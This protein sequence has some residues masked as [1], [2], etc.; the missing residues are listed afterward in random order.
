MWKWTRSIF[1]SLCFMAIVIRLFVGEVCAVSG[2]SMVH[3]ILPGDWLWINKTTYGA[4]MPECYLDIPVI[5]IL[6]WMIPS[7]ICEK[8]TNW[9]YKRIKG[10][11]SPQLGDMLV[12]NST[13]TKDAILVKRIVAIPGDSF[14][15][16]K[17]VLYSNKHFLIQ[18][19]T[20]IPASTLNR[21]AEYPQRTDWTEQDYG[22]V[23]LPKRGDTITITNDNF[24][25][26]APVIRY[27][28]NTLSLE[29]GK[30]YIN[31]KLDPVYCFK[32]NYY[33]VM[34]DNRSN[35]RDSRSF[36]FVSERAIIGMID[37]VLFSVDSE[38]KN[39]MGIRLNRLFHP[40]L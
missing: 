23:Y 29:R 32:Y 40:L 7:S 6:T 33:F 26:L 16:K 28:D 36:G 37:F 18:P 19:A 35:S 5:N 2:D 21:L 14:L 13:E 25:Y 15:I 12:F 34:G 10:T 20:V 30:C 9:D 3:T 39:W 27:E 24:L 22:P 8:K 38:K 17:G 1:I 4:R 31:G 11:R